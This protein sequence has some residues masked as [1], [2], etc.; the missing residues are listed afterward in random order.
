M[1]VDLKMPVMS[2]LDMIKFVRKS[3]NERPF[4]VYTAHDNSMVENNLK[5][6]NVNKVINKLDI[7]YLINTVEEMASA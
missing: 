5:K 1:I 7:G 6:L 4:L 3:D 2:G